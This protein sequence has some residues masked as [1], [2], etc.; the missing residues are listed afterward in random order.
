VF[1]VT[2]L[3]PGILLA[4]VGMRALVQERRLASQ[5]IRD[6]VERAAELAVRAVDR[7]LADWQ[8]ALE[9][10]G[11]IDET[12]AAQTAERLPARIVQAMKEPGSGVFLAFASGGLEAWPERAL[13]Y[14]PSWNEPE[15]A[16]DTAFAAALAQAESVELQQRN[17]AQ[18]AV[19]YNALLAEAGFEDRT[20]VLFRLARTSLKAGRDKE[21][22]DRLREL[23]LSTNGRI[24]ALPASLVAA[25]ET[26]SYWASQRA[27]DRLAMDALTFYRDLIEGRWRLEKSR[28]LFY[29]EK[30][31]E[32]LQ[33][34]PAAAADAA[35]WIAIDDRKRELADAVA[36]L[37]DSR[38]S[39]GSPAD[40]HPVFETETERYAAFWR[41]NESR[42]E[43]R[44]IAVV[45]KKEWLKEHVWPAVFAGTLKEGLDVH[46]IAGNGQALF[47]SAGAPTEGIG[48][49]FLAAGAIQDGR[50]P[51]RLQIWP[52]DP[53]ALAADL[54]RRQ[55]LYFV[56]LSLLV[57]MLAFGAY[58]TTRVVRREME[59]ARLKSDFVSTVSH[60]FRSPLTAIRQLCEMLTR[61]RVPGEERRQEY[62]QLIGREGDRLAR[63]VEN[64][65][66]FSRVEAGRKQY[67]FEPLDAGLWL[68]AVV[69]DFQSQLGNSVTIEARIPDSLPRVLADHE[70]LASAV[71]N[72]LDNAVKYSPDS[73]RVWIEAENGGGSLTIRVRDRGVGIA[74]ADRQ[75]IF[76]KFYR[77]GE[78]AEQVKGAGLGLSLVKHIVQAHGGRV[79]F[80]SSPGQG[81]T[82]SIHLKAAANGNGVE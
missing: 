79:E 21:A 42:D 29:A 77:G 13:L 76:E 69:S 1:V 54:A 53:N 3:L 65:L 49:S 50:L 33:N 43:P 56:M 32:W 64:V 46:L 45:L 9:G 24:G 6:R 81:T 5:L 7:Q 27:F 80:L 71:T 61:G 18:A 25:Y 12:L 68:S 11:P 70:A 20:A 52:R 75:H 26:C 58:L 31:R 44:G 10:L 17:Y 38:P 36:Q 66:D 28:Y 15:P 62:Y 48:K 19:R 14:P 59:I 60:E 74:E 55:D 82:F 41:F 2:I 4:I 72:L 51:W 63:L 39:P 34:S 35:H 40:R 57:A 47:S 67:R 78:L 23:G 16:L 30:A 73:D 37:L 8:N 22:L